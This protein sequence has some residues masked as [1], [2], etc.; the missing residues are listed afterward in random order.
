MIRKKDILYPLFTSVIIFILWEFLSIIFNVPEYLLP[1]PSLVLIALFQSFPTYLPHFFVTF[2]EAI[3][4]FFLAL[5]IGVFFVG[6]FE[7]SKII[8]Q[9]IYPYIIVVRIAPVIALAPFLVLW[10]GNGMISK[11]LTATIMSVFFVVVN[12]TKG[13]SEVESQS[14]DLMKSLSA[15]KWQIL[16]K[17]KFPNAIPYLFSGL[18]M[19]IATSI[20]G[21]V[22]AE[23][24]GANEGLGYLILTN[25]YYLRTTHMF[26]ALFLLF[27]GGISLFG[28]ISFIESKFFNKYSVGKDYKD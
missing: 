19:A 9:G 17:L 12:L 28:I 5:I 2:T 6:L 10:F 7:L 21:A 16:T 23:F 24:V 14:L 13:F 3:L 11:I 8:K 25:F 20:A 18:K 4:G 1:R 27:A 22:V 15:S 26:A